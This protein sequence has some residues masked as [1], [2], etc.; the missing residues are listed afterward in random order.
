MAGAWLTAEVVDEWVEWHP[1]CGYAVFGLLIFRLGWALVGGHYARWAQFWPS[2]AQTLAYLRGRWAEA[3]G[4]SPLARWSVC[5]ILL[6][7]ATQVALG[8]FATDGYFV[9]GPLARQIDSELAEQLTSWHRQV[10]T[11]LW[12]LLGLHLAAVAWYQFGRRRPLVQA[13]VHGRASAAD[14][15]I[16]GAASIWTL[17]LAA[18]STIAATG[19]A[20]YALGAFG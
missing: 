11:I 12:A 8:L 16:D 19:A 20:L 17:T 3:P 13:M 10:A 18:L 6:V 9:E 1:Y 4:H 7:L 14:G 2:P 15:S 5:A